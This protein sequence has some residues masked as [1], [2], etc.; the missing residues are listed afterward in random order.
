MDKFTN[1]EDLSEVI[2]KLMADEKF[3][4]IVEAVRE[5][6][7]ANAEDAS[8]DSSHKNAESAKASD[9]S[10]DNTPTDSPVPAIPQLSPELMSKLPMI[11]SM[12]SGD[13][14]GD[15]KGESR[16]ADRKRLLQALRP[17]L[18]K[19]RKEAVDSIVN[20]AGI[21]DLFGL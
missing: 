12:L 11:M 3:G 20:I 1:G 19:S 5:S 8:S 2:G 4:E 7:S 10:I 17:F 13:K 15:G 21:A 18:S 16:L 6:F 9:D 14:K